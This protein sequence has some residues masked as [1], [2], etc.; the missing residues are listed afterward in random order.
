M[1]DVT[2]LSKRQQALGGWGFVILFSSKLRGLIQNSLG[3]YSHLAC[4]ELNSLSCLLYRVKEIPQLHHKLLGQAFERAKLLATETYVQMSQ[5]SYLFLQL[6]KFSCAWKERKEGTP[7]SSWIYD[8][9]TKKTPPKK[10]GK[11]NEGKGFY[12]KQHISGFL[13]LKKILFSIW[14]GDGLCLLSVIFK[15]MF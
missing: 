1:A 15:F 8:R 2:L 5:R 3:S 14:I 4:V 9:K 13:L 11:V 10:S 7:R 6:L 12:N